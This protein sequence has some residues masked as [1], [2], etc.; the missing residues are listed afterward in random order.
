MSET[1]LAYFRAPT[2]KA[3]VKM[4]LETEKL[5]QYDAIL[6]RCLALRARGIAALE[7]IPEETLGDRVAGCLAALGF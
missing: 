2:V 6:A 1:E 7:A 4:V 5:S 3:V